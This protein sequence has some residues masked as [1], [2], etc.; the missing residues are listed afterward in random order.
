MVSDGSSIPEERAQGELFQEFS[1]GIAEHIDIPLEVRGDEFSGLIRVI[2]LIRGA[3][4]GLSLVRE[5]RR[6]YADLFTRFFEIFFQAFIP[7][8]KIND[9]LSIQIDEVIRLEFD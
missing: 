5:W 8:H 7:S 3:V 9:N 6:V 4:S 2:F 1:E